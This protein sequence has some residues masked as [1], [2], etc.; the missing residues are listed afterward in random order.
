MD[1]CHCIYKFSL[2]SPCA[3]LKLLWAPPS[4]HEN[5]VE[6]DVQ[7]KRPA[8]QFV[9]EHD[10][11]QMNEL[12]LGSFQLLLTSHWILS[13][14]LSQWKT[15]WLSV[16]VLQTGLGRTLLLAPRIF[17]PDAVLTRL[18]ITTNTQAMKAETAGLLPQMTSSHFWICFSPVRPRTLSSASWS[19][20]LQKE[21]WQWTERLER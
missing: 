1:C 18:L 7:L 16:T 21:P 19:L 2:S 12:Q 8:I 3:S 17:L 4:S 11:H 20:H 5:N 6:V 13:D 9:N 14:F 10:I 15:H